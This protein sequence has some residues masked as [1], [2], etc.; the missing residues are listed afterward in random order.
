MN[1]ILRILAVMI[2]TISMSSVAASSL[3]FETLE[4]EK[5]F[6]EEIIRNE[7]TDSWAKEGVLA[8]REAGLIPKLTGMPPYKANITREQFA[9]L[10][11]RTVEIIIGEEGELSAEGTFSDTTNEAALKANKM[12]IINGRE[13]GMFDPDSEATRQEIATMISRAIDYVYKKTGKDLANLTGGVEKFADNESIMPYAREHIGRLVASGIMN[14][15]DDGGVLNA[16]PRSS[17][18]VQESILLLYRVYENSV[19]K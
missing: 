4:N 3:T 16:R 5:I 10:V 6:S 1:T 8:A 14:G 13:N 2:L 15:S 11:V 19:L 9:E 12:G 7:Q 17:C 18:T